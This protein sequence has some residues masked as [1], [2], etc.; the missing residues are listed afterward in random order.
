MLDVLSLF[1][2]NRFEKYV[3]ERYE[4]WIY[5]YKKLTRDILKRRGIE[6]TKSNFELVR[7]AVERAIK[8]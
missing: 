5:G 6:A 7:S 2:I 8:G 4:P 1:K 3:D